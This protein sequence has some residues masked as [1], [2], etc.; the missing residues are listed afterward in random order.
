MRPNAAAR[1]LVLTALLAIV[2]SQ[3]DGQR[4][5][6]RG[7]AAGESR[8][9]V[10]CSEFMAPKRSVKGTLVG[11]EECLMQDHGIVDKVKNYHRVD[12]GITGTLSGY[13]VKDGARQNYF[14]SG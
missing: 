7:Q 14:T 2:V 5:L 8:S 1:K 12:M 10:R 6:A 13:I 9:A 11:Q 4:L 3:E